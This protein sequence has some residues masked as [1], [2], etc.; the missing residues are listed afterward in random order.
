[1]QSFQI[2]LL[3][4][5]VLSLLYGIGEI[6][7]FSRNKFSWLLSAAFFSIFIM[8]FHAYLLFTGILIEF[9]FLLGWYI[10][11]NFM[12]GPFFSRY[13]TERL[14]I[15]SST[16]LLPH[17]IPAII[18]AFVLIFF[19]LE[20]SV[21]IRESILLAM[22]SPT[23]SREF[24][25]LGFLNLHFLIYIFISGWKILGSIGYRK[26]LEENYSRIMLI[27]LIYAALVSLISFFGFL[28]RNMFLLQVSILM[29]NSILLGLYLL[30][31]RLPEFFGELEKI[32]SKGKYMKS[33]LKD[34]DLK[35]LESKIEE[36]MQI[37]KIYCD[38]DITLKSLATE[39]GLSQ[40]QLS[41]FFNDFLKK[42]F[43]S[44]VNGYRISDAKK[45][46]IEERETTVL[47][48]AY[49]VGFNSKSAF[50]S[51]FQKEVGCSPSAYR[52]KTL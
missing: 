13:A 1:M 14:R 51:A 33:R 39:L 16:K 47:A 48:I 20:G 30:R 19:H 25:L 27:I 21:P 44:Y 45:L 32:V 26:G 52:S 12:I 34:L 49:Q 24:P 22:D 10:P 11:F 2:S 42:N 31:L 28:F 3:I 5:A 17:L 6:I 4:V 43:V 29:L 40:H 36:L 9:P 46:L 50:N 37:D 15:S 7:S 23:S 41:E 8:S 18:S 35:I 38:E